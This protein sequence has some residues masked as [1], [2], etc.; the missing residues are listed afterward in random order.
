LS[1]TGC[2]TGNYVTGMAAG[3]S[4]EQ[5][6]WTARLGAG[7]LGGTPRLAADD[8]L[9]LLEEIAYAR[10]IHQDARAI[11]DLATGSRRFAGED[12]AEVIRLLTGCGL[13]TTENGSFSFADQDLAHFLAANHVARRHPRGPKWWQ[14]WTEK[15]LA[16]RPDWPWPA[17]EAHL[18]LAALW[19]LEAR[20]AVE[21]RL[22][23]LLRDEHWHPNIRFVLELLR[24]NLVPDSGFTGRATEV[25]REAL[26]GDGLS[27]EHWLAAADWLHALDPAATG[28]VLDD[29]VRVPQDGCRPQRRLLAV[30]ELA[31]HNPPRAQE[32]LAILAAGLVGKPE[33]RLETAR[34]IG[35]RDAA[36]GVRAM[37]SLAK[38]P[39]MRELRAPAAIA[40][41]SAD[42]MREL[43]EPQSGLSDNGRLKLLAEL[44]ARD[45]GAEQATADRIVATA[46]DPE[47]P[48][49]VADLVHPHD[50][51]AAMRILESVAWSGEADGEARLH[52]V[53]KIGEFASDQAIPALQRLSRDP[54]AD[55]EIR[56]AAA[57]HIVEKHGGPIAALVDLAEDKD[58]SEGAR[59]RAA[60][61]IGKTEPTTGARLLVAIAPRRADILTRAF[62]LDPKVAL[63]ALE[64]LAANSQLSGTRRIDVVDAVGA[65]LDRTTRVRLYSRI[66][67]TSRDDD[68]MRAARKASALDSTRGHRLMADL[69][70]RTTAGHQYRVTAALDGGAAAAPVLRE[71][72]TDGAV[73]DEL[74]LKTAKALDRYNRKAAEPVLRDLAEKARP[75]NLRLEAALAL[76]GK[77]AVKALV[78]I[79][80]DRH[81]K[82]EL[83]FQAAL[84]A[85]Q[86][87]PAAGRAA[88]RALDE[89]PRISSGVRNQV[90]RHLR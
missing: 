28:T 53:K 82:D 88:M 21:R 45:A 22:N 90:R 27:D 15:Y 31:K 38:S 79:S 25:L 66:T 4:L 70:A 6:R 83:R 49:R 85:K 77:H 12:R 2:H 55:G 24:R 33:D 51:A 48:A 56:F 62:D 74:R 37:L 5:L 40:T 59:I 47:T 69:A 34:L 10:I 57:R 13:F 35:D 61:L 7:K 81:A 32:N 67:E 84:R 17:L 11:L 26:R 20:P 9:A 44:L 36:L 1:W 19:W 29:L 78:S 23:R 18:Y 58:A 3:D 86:K 63:A 50:H 72:A 89:D 71:L 54:A 75:D 65:K 60:S 42:V 8:A 39:A 14:P 76:H 80:A 68:A 41:G 30:D 16:P 43:T 87:D 46:A 52:A 64:R 73:P